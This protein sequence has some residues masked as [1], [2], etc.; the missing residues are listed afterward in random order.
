MPC[1]KVGDQIGALLEGGLN[2]CPLGL[3]TFLCRR[4]RIDTAT[5]E[6]QRSNSGDSESTGK[7]PTGHFNLSFKERRQETGP[8]IH[9]FCTA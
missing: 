7:L 1:G 4:Y 3:G 5:G 9:A 6:A 8:P 2:I